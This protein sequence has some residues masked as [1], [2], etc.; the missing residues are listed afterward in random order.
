M[1]LAAAAA[2]WHPHICLVNAGVKGQLIYWQVCP[3][4]GPTLH[5]ACWRDDPIVNSARVKGHELVPETRLHFSPI[6]QYFSNVFVVFPSWRR[7]EG[8]TEHQ[9]RCFINRIDHS[10]VRVDASVQSSVVSSCSDASRV[11]DCCSACWEES[12]LCCTLS[13]SNTHLP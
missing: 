6:I 2:S 5:C 3:W 12:R 9:A 4:E 7:N 8:T 13:E 11:T 1:S 10:R